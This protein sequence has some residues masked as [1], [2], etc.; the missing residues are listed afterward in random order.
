[1]IEQYRSRQRV[2]RRELGC[3]GLSIHSMTISLPIV[4]E[5]WFFVRLEMVCA[6][7]P[8]LSRAVPQDGNELNS[9]QNLEV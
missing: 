3:E 9:M 5:L 7:V 1:M 4:V 8:A 2:L 6:E